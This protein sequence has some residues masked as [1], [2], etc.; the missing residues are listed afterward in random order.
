MCVLA[1]YSHIACSE[2]IPFMELASLTSPTQVKEHHG[3]G[4]KLTAT[5]S[6]GWTPLHHAARLEKKE[7]VQYIVENGT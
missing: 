2:G 3:K 5:D 4:A 1:Q 7:V 6:N